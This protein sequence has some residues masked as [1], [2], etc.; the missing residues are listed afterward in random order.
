MDSTDKCRVFLGNLTSEVAFYLPYTSGTLRAFAETDPQIR[1]ACDFQPFIF[2]ATHGVEALAKQIINPSVVGLSI[3]VWNEQRSLKLAKLIKQNYPD[4]LIILGGPQVPSEGA[5]FLRE[6]SFVD[7]LV[8]FEGEVP[9][10]KI[11][12][13]EINKTKNWSHIENITFRS[14]GQIKKTQATRMTK[15]LDDSPSPYLLGYFDAN[16]EEA[17]KLG[18]NCAT[19]V[20]TNRGC[21]YTCTFCDWGNNTY[22]KLRQFPLEKV[23][24][25]LD[26]LSNRLSEI[27]IADANFGILPRDLDIA[28]YAVER[29]VINQKLKTVQVIL[30]KKKNTRTREI[31]KM[32]DDHSLS[33]FGETIGV[34]SLTREVLKNVNREN[35]SFSDLNELLS[36]YSHSGV[37]TYIELVVGLPG[38]TRASFLDT[39]DLAWQLRPSDVR[40]YNLILLPN[41]QLASARE[42]DRWQ[43]KTSRVK[44]IEGGEEESEYN[45]VVIGNVDLSTEDYY[46]LRKITLLID[47]LHGGK[48]TF[49]LAWYLNRTIGMRLTD[50]YLKLMSY[51]N[52]ADWNSS[53]LF[54]VINNH[55]FNTYNSRQFNSF[56]GPHSPH[57][58][59]WTGKFFMKQTFQ[60]LCIS[61]NREE[62]YTEIYN[63]LANIAPQIDRSLIK[64]LLYFQHSA[65]LRP[66][67][68][69]TQPRVHS[70]QF[71]WPR[72][73][74]GDG[75]L[76]DTLT[77]YSLNRK[78]VSRQKTSVSRANPDWFFEAAGG[79]YFD[80][81]D[82]FIH[83]SEHCE[84]QTPV[85]VSEEL[86]HQPVF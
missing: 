9:F 40:T 59:D 83:S 19:V 71:D 27:Y 31:A 41:S 51:F 13:E 12:R 15:T 84:V 70:T 20:E 28:K 2:H 68:E 65:M 45:E 11:L 69:M 77:T 6:H 86:N 56:V 47:I 80:K 48:W 26:Y 55:Y 42:R 35:L 73:F 33:I 14:D 74:W 17:Q 10:Q 76:H 57:G 67:D 24:M 63:F 22:E 30:A 25:E 72:Y 4:C 18:K 29:A 3:Y 5:S 37:R 54:K 81:I 61:E 23:K 38:E 79:Q 36:E 62:F 60:W 75:T 82:R 8:H 46:F 7:L 50:F 66:D 39:L 64:D 1:E 85:S 49:F 58:V 21:P 53:V 43:L 44:I 34:Q 16:I 52:N 32:L 78:F